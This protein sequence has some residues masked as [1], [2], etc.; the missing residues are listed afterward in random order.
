MLNSIII[1]SEC[2]AT[3]KEKKEMDATSRLIIHIYK[4]IRYV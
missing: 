3:A 4:F 2:A 1:E